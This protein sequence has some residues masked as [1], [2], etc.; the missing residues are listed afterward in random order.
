MCH[1]TVAHAWPRLVGGDSRVCQ[2]TF[3]LAKAGFQ[4]DQSL[5]S[6]PPE[7][8][9]SFGAKFT[10]KA[11]R[12][13]DKIG[14]SVGPLMV[15]SAIFQTITKW[16]IGWRDVYWQ[17]KPQAGQRFVIFQRSF[18]WQGDEFAL[19]SVDENVSQEA[20]IADFPRVFR[21]AFH[22]IIKSDFVPPFILTDN[23]SGSSWAVTDRGSW[24]VWTAEYDGT[25]LRCSINFQPMVDQAVFLMPKEV[26]RLGALLDEALGPGLNEGTL[27]PTAR[28]RGYIDIIWGNAALRP[29]ALTDIPYSS[30]H[31][32]DE[33]LRAWSTSN[34]KRRAL[35]T[36]ING[37]YPRAESAL[38][39]YYRTTFH[40]P[41][42]GA[43]KMALYTI[44]LMY[45][46]YFVFPGG[47]QSDQNANPWKQLGHG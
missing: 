40:I 30:R 26:Q 44:D 36:R 47:V 35:Y 18:S 3:E 29:W 27:Q 12:S 19:Y 34:A 11:T 39:D 38:S 43:R 4:S 32:V 23:V 5:P 24:S 33:G 6:A 16:D 1:S 31:E 25:Q 22:A 17:I 9:E 15:D 28:L 42:A 41:D 8:S 37:Q 10:V 13:L 2:Q 14:A 7:L 21:E 20:V 46:L 45:R